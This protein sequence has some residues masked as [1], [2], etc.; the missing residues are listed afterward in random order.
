MQLSLPTKVLRET[1]QWSRPK[2]A[3]AASYS[4]VAIRLLYVYTLRTFMYTYEQHQFM[5]A[6]IHVCAQ[7]CHV[8]L[9]RMQ[10]I[11]YL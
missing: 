2:P 4:K 1:V 8:L 5:C 11:M 6:H 3:T 7:V 10:Y 9:T